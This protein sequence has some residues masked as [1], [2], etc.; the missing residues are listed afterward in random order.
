MQWIKEKK[1]DYGLKVKV[2]IFDT[3]ISIMHHTNVQ[4]KLRFY[5]IKFSLRTFF[6]L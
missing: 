2:D 5:I 1:N 6:I 3:P 4:G